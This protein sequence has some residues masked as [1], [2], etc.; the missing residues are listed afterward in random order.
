MDYKRL[1]SI[2][3]LRTISIIIMVVA[4]SSPYILVT[5]HSIWLRIISSIAAPLFIFLSGY[6]FFVSFNRNKNFY[7]KIFQSFYLILSAVFLD[8]VIWRILPFQTFDVLYLISFALLINLV[9][10]KL[11]LNVKLIFTFLFIFASFILQYVLD[12]RFDINDNQLENIN[13]N[14][15]NLLSIFEVKRCLIDGWFPL[16]PWLGISILGHIV[17]QKSELIFNHLKFIKFSSLLASIIFGILLI[18]NQTYVQEREG[19][20][21]LFYPPSLYFIFFEISVIFLLFSIFNKFDF[22]K[23]SKFKFLCLLGRKSLFIYLYHA[24]I[25]SFLFQNYFIPLS[26]LLFSITIFLFIISCFIFAFIAEFLE[27]NNCLKYIPFKAI[28]GLK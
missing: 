24:F 18:Y 17:A 28:L 1:D 6:S 16:F 9:L 11:S 8:A 19:Y 5:P 12:Y 23:K 4:N 26:P 13:W 25:I 15:I 3:I 22:I 10:F 21:E 7:Y 2:D 20:L 14:E 27:K